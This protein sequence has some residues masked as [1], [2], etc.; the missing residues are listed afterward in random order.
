MT[1]VIKGEK[2][3][4]S[5]VALM[6]SIVGLFLLSAC[7]TTMGPPAVHQEAEQTPTSVIVQ[8]DDLGRLAGR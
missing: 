1:R 8:G 5:K 3:M 7:A 2:D 4:S 6:V